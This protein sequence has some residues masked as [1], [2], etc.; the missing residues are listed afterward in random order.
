MGMRDRF[1]GEESISLILE[2]SLLKDNSLKLGY[3][4]DLV[5]GGLEAKAP[6]SHELLLRYA[7]SN[8][9]KEFERVIQRTP[10]FRF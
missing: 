8:V 10:R 6:T 3:S 9:T 1:R 2:Y 5:F 7:L 4:F